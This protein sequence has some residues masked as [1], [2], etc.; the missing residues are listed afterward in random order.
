MDG[1]PEAGEAVDGLGGSTTAQEERNGNVKTWQEGAGGRLG[2]PNVQALRAPRATVGRTERRPA[3][4][5]SV[6]HGGGVPGPGA[7]M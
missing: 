7:G 2:S 6:R 1:R 3:S 4:E 5:A